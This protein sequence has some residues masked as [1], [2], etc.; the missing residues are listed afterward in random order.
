MEEITTNIHMDGEIKNVLSSL[1]KAKG[2]LKTSITP[3]GK[4]PYFKSDYITLDDLL[5]KVDPV[6]QK[7]G[8][9]ILQFPTGVGLVTLLYHEKSGEY[10]S[11]YYE[12]LLD[13]QNAQGVGSAL[14]YAKRQ[15]VQAI[16]GLSAGKE[17]DDDG[18]K[19]SHEE[20]KFEEENP[21]QGK[22]DNSNAFQIAKVALQEINSLEGLKVWKEAQ[23]EIIRNNSKVGELFKAKMAELKLAE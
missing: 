10:I 11:S 17:E 9:G 18:H 1:F 12:L 15:T 7:Y 14:T 5:K 20:Q 6:C 23:P 8:L 13:N 3:G 21:V 2:E 19:A 22:V 16:F 4:N